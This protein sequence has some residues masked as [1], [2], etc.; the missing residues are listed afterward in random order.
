M[1]K[2]LLIPLLLFSSIILFGQDLDLAPFYHGVA[3]RDPLEIT[4]K[5][6]ELI[7]QIKISVQ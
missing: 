4:S 5:P 2:T 3:S 7:D 6:S 1:K